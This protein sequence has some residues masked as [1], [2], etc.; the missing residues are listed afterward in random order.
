MTGLEELSPPPPSLT[1]APLLTQQPNSGPNWPEHQPPALPIGPQ[2]FSSA[3]VICYI[4]QLT[5][6]FTLLKLRVFCP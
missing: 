1:P 4:C 5:S 2:S 6:I 3:T